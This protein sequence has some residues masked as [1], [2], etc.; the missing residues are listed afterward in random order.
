MTSPL[1]VCKGIAK[2]FKLRT[3]GVRNWL[4]QILG[5]R[6]EEWL[7]GCMPGICMAFAGSNSDLKLNDRLPIMEQIHEKCCTRKRC[8]VKKNNLKRTTRALQRTQATTNGYFGGYIG[9]RQPAGAFETKNASTN[10]TLC[11][12]NLG[13]GKAAQF[14]SVSGRMITDLEMN[15]TYRGAVE[16]FN[17]C[18]NLHKSDALFAECIR[19]FNSHSLD[20]CSWLYRLEASQLSKALKE[21][22]LQTFIPPTKKPN[23]RSIYSRVNE[24]EAHGSRRLCYPCKLLSPCEFLRYWK[25]EPLLG[26]T[27]HMPVR[28]QPSDGVLCSNFSIVIG[29]R[30]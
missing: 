16:V 1:L 4:G 20:G 21:H 8:L 7:N 26:L 13:K 12:T 9:K 24:C 6:N 25:V 30:S 2:D 19:T 29:F 14:C 11:E 5:L 17:L 10:C 3:S 22:T 23:R 27:A 15:S 28:S 18:R